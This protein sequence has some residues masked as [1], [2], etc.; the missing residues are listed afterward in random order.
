MKPMPMSEKNYEEA[1]C[2]YLHISDIGGVLLTNGWDHHALKRTAA[3]FK[4]DWAKLQ[5]RHHMALATYEEGNLTLNEYLTRVVFYRKRPFTSAQVQ[6]FMFSQSQPFTKMIEL[7]H[8][9]KAKYGLKIIVVSNEGRE[10]NSYR[11][12]NFKL[13]EFVDVFISSCFVHARKPDLEILRVALD[14]A[15]VPAQK[16]VYIENRP[17]FVEVARALGI[18]GLLH[19]AYGS[20]RAELASLGLS[21]DEKAIHSYWRAAN[22]LSV[23]QTYLYDNPLLKEPLKMSHVKPLV[24]G[25]L[26]TTPG[27]NFIYVHLNRVIKKYDLNMFYIAGPDH[28]G[29]AIVGNTYLEGTYSEIYPS[30][31]QDEPGLKELF[32]QF[33]FPGGTSSHVAPTTPGSIHERGELGYSLS[34]AFRA[35]FDNPDLIVACIIGDGQAETGPLAR[36]WQSNKFLD[37]ATD[38]AVLPILHLN[39]YKISNPTVLARIDHEELEQFIRGCGW[40][41]YFVEG[42]KLDAMHQRMA[43]VLEKAIEDIHEI[44][45]NARNKGD[46]DRPRWPK[47]AYLKQLMQEKLIEHKQYI[48]SHGEDLPEI[49]NWK[50]G[51]P[52]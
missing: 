37:P 39:G 24:V 19:T 8:N 42:D 10:L 46:T 12:R 32:K 20:T 52:N 7:V 11:I 18:Q 40:T 14:V 33:S 26:G 38:G 50:W 30:V 15:Q 44:Q 23:G 31:G 28:G 48:D 17:T 35:A 6:K 43:G 29:P 13:D 47:G 1:D 16:V 36:A 3:K 34:H 22:Y 2:D 27:Q 5:K 9:L 21:I 49:R 25:L 45:S 51:T 4:L 41:P